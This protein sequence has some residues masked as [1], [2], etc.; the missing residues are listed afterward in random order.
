MKLAEL[1]DVH[2]MISFSACYSFK[3]QQGKETNNG[4]DVVRCFNLVAIAAVKKKNSKIFTQQHEIAQTLYTQCD[5]IEYECKLFETSKK[6]RAG[7]GGGRGSKEGSVMNK[8]N[9]CF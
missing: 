3:Q 8:V 9:L 4:N 5:R 2:L 6:K 1:H 7:G